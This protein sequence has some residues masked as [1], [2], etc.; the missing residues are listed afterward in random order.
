[1]K[2]KNHELSRRM[3][4]GG[5]LAGVS[6]L[7]MSACTATGK[8]TALNKGDWRDG[9]AN[10]PAQG[11]A[12][13]RMR[14]VS[15]KA[16]TNLSGNFYR[17]GPA[18]LHYGFAHAEHWFDGDGMIHRMAFDGGDVTHSAEFVQTNKRRIEQEHGKFM[19]PG[20]GTHG[21]PDFPVRGP[22][23]TNA[24]NTSVAMSGGELLALWEGGSAY[25]LDPETLETRGPKTW[26]DDLKGMPFLA[27]PK[28]E[29]D[30]TFWNL[31]VSGPRVA[32]Y[33]IDAAGAL[34]KFGMVNMG[35][36]AYIHDWTMT[37][38]HLVI[39]VQPW[40]NT[41]QIPPFI[42]GFEWRPQDGLKILI[43]DKDD[44]TKQRWSQAPARAFYHTGAA[45]EESDGTIRLDVA[46]Y[47]TPTLGSGGGRDMISGLYQPGD[48]PAGD[49]SMV[50]IPT[51]GDAQIIGTGVDGEFP[52]VDPRRHGLKRDL[53]VLPT[54]TARNRPG[55]TGLTLRDWKSG[56]ND[57]FTFGD[58]HMV[59]EILFV[60]KPGSS[61]E[62][63]SWLIGTTLNIAE[64][65]TEVCLFD[66]AGVSD[67]PVAVWRADYTWPLGFHGTWS[68]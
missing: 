53:T 42:D 55:Q 33:K 60:P 48:Y 66:A 2:T 43:V 34:E 25:R 54:G 3:I 28:R 56:T 47:P 59:E 6:A 15:G 41:R 4:L 61:S 46:L 49:L 68:A 21:D 45:W 52:Q 14:L 44:F 13:S 64:G 51:K 17:N 22:D 36:A 18:Q 11:F 40:I 31:G 58:S 37:D 50:V 7:A 20:F 24:A 35:A 8:A 32:I 30:G 5:G 62:R 16:P 19:A 39:L 1:M 10:A 9:F 29:P 57:S 27:H 23:D 63:D 26:R 38:R 67:G 65:A 12:P